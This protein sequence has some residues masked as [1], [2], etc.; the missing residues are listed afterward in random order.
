MQVY[1]LHMTSKKDDA[2]RAWQAMSRLFLS[3]ETHDRFHDACAAVG[4][5]HPGSLKALLSID[6]DDA[7]PM[8]TLAEQ[9][10]CD[11]SYITALVDALEQLGYV[12]RRVSAADRRVKLV[13]I[14]DTGRKARAEAVRILGSPPRA[15]DRLNAAQVR[16]LAD[17]MEQVAEEYPPLP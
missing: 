16:A 11:A 15:L 13:E 6:A 8:R 7:P 3:S 4:L 1:Y 5:P 12:E 10:H 9:L 17:L 14:T 2:R